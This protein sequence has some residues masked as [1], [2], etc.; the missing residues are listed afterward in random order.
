[1][2]AS[3]RN[4]ELCYFLLFVLGVSVV[5][6]ATAVR[7]KHLGERARW[8]RIVVVII[9]MMIIIVITIFVCVYLSLSLCVFVC[10]S[11]S[12]STYTYI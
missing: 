5:E 8:L 9:I 2:L 3:V 7:S 6:S 11:L 12:L 4:T 1:M 10:I